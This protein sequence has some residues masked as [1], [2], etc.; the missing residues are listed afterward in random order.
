MLF[1][2]LIWKSV[3]QTLSEELSLQVTDGE[4]IKGKVFQQ[5]E[6]LKSFIAQLDSVNTQKQVVA[7]EQPPVDIPT[8]T[9]RIESK[10]EQSDEE[11]SD[12]SP[13]SSP[14]SF[15]MQRFR[16][17][18][19]PKPTKPQ[20]DDFYLFSLNEDFIAVDKT[21]ENNLLKSQHEETKIQSGSSGEQ[22]LF[23]CSNCKIS[24]ELSATTPSKT[25]NHLLK[26]DNQSLACMF[27]LELFDKSLQPEYEH[28]VRCHI[29][30]AAEWLKTLRINYNNFLFD[31]IF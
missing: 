8:T 1:E 12:P 6:M 3:C 2:S 19:T 28:H 25:Q 5:N 16:K 21:L 9:S 30:L 22:G 7:V 15:F 10:D 31:S 24:I 23:T 14:S 18:P 20:K 4:S 26:C 17:K 11:E 13:G 29:S 27:C